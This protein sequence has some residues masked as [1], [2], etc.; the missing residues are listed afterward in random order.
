MSQRLNGKLT[1]SGCNLASTCPWHYIPIRTTTQTICCWSSPAV[2]SAVSL[3]PLG[4]CLPQIYFSHLLWNKQLTLFAFIHPLSGREWKAISIRAMRTPGDQERK[5]EMQRRK[6][7]TERGRVFPFIITISGP[8]CSVV[9]TGS[10]A[11]ITVPLSAMWSMTNLP[12][13]INPLN[14]CNTVLKSASQRK[15]KSQMKSL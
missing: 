7:E 12:Q 15:E 10:I 14:S 4:S 6:W 5:Q 3:W 11:S 13:F 1:E 2:A 8:F 9:V